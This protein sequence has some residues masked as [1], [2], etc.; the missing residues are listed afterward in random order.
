MKKDYYHY[1]NKNH[2]NLPILIHGD[3]SQT[4]TQLL[5]DAEKYLIHPYGTLIKI[6][7][8]C[9]KKD[10]SKV[11]NLY[12]NR[13]EKYNPDIRI[14]PYFKKEYIT[15]TILLHV[16]RTLWSRNN[17]DRT[18]SERLPFGE[19]NIHLEINPEVF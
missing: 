14:R 13:L 15:M 19:R 16:D 4:V 12:K 9:L 3:Y 6:N 2:Y 17:Q 11:Y 5:S 18:L 1:F 8:I 7:H 10:Y